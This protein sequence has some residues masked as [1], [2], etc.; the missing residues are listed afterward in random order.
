MEPSEEAK[1]SPTI[2]ST[3]TTTTFEALPDNARA[4]FSITGKAAVTVALLPIIGHGTDIRIGLVSEGK[5]VPAT[6]PIPVISAYSPST[7][8]DAWT[9]VALV[10][11]RETKTARLLVNGL[12]EA[13][14]PDVAAGSFDGVAKA[15]LKDKVRYYAGVV[16][17]IRLWSIGRDDKDIGQTMHTRSS[18]V[19]PYLAGYW[20]L[21][22]GT[23]SLCHDSTGLSRPLRLVTDD[24]SLTVGKSWVLS[25]ANITSRAGIVR[26]VLRLRDG[27][28]VTTA[29]A[30]ALYC[31]QEDPLQNLAEEKEGKGDSVSKANKTRAHVVLAFGVRQA[32]PSSG[33]PNGSED[34][35]LGCLGLLDFDLD[36]QGILASTTGL[37]G[38]ESSMLT[39]ALLVNNSAARAAAD[40]RSKRIAEI[41]K[42][43]A[44]FHEKVKQ[45]QKDRTGGEWTWYGPALGKIAER[46]RA[47]ETDWDREIT[48]LKTIVVGDDKQIEDVILRSAEWRQQ[49]R[50]AAAEI[51]HLDQAFPT[52][53]AELDAKFNAETDWVET[54]P[55]RTWLAAAG[56]SKEYVKSKALLADWYRLVPSMAGECARI[57][58]EWENARHKLAIDTW[59]QKMRWRRQIDLLRTP[60]ADAKIQPLLCSIDAAGLRVSGMMLDAEAC[61]L[62]G[63]PAL[64]ESAKGEILI[65]ARGAGERL[66]SFQYD[67]GSARSIAILRGNATG[68]GPDGSAAVA[69]LPRSN[70]VKQLHVE[71]RRSVSNSSAAVDVLLTAT[72]AGDAPQSV[73]ERWSEVSSDPQQLSATINGMISRTAVQV[74]RIGS[75]DVP[76][77]IVTPTSA[78]TPGITKL[79]FP[80]GTLTSLLPGS[81]LTTGS[82]VFH[83]SRSALAGSKEVEIKILDFPK[84]EIVDPEADDDDPL[85]G[86]PSGSMLTML[87]YDYSRLAWSDRP[88]ANLASGSMIAS[89]VPLDLGVKVSI[90]DLVVTAEHTRT[91][92]LKGV[93]AG[94]S[95]TFDG[96][97][98][99][100]VATSI[101]DPTSEA[102]PATA[103]GTG[104]SVELYFKPALGQHLESA[105]LEDR[106][107]PHRSV[108]MAY[109]DSVKDATVSSTGWARECVLAL[110]R[111]IDT[112]TLDHYHVVLQFRGNGIFCPA[113]HIPSI[114]S[115]SFTVE[116]QVWFTGGN[117]SQGGV[118]LKVEI[119]DFVIELKREACTVTYRSNVDGQPDLSGIV[120]APLGDIG[121][122]LQVETWTHVSVVHDAARR[123]AD[124]YLDGENVASFAVPN[125]PDQ[126]IR[127]QGLAVS[128]IFSAPAQIADVAVWHGICSPQRSTRERLRRFSTEMAEVLLYLE[129]QTDGSVR[130]ISSNGFPVRVDSPSGAQATRRSSQD[131]HWQARD[132]WVLVGQL[133]GKP[134]RLRP[135][136]TSL[137]GQICSDDWTHVAVT[138]DI[139]YAASLDNLY[140][141]QKSVHFRSC[142]FIEISGNAPFTDG[143]IS[144]AICMSDVGRDTMLLTCG[145]AGLVKGATECR[146]NPLELST[147]DGGRLRIAWVD[148]HGTVI[149]RETNCRLRSGVPTRITLTREYYNFSVASG[150]KHIYI[151]SL[152][153]L[154]CPR[155]QDL[156]GSVREQWP[157]KIDPASLA[158]LPDDLAVMESSAFWFLGGAPWI[159][160]SNVQ[161]DRQDTDVEMDG[162]TG[163]I[164]EFRV[165]QG[166]IDPYPPSTPRGVSA[167]LVTWLNFVEGE[168]LRAADHAGKA[169]GVFS[170]K[171]RPTWSISLNPHES[172]ISA[173]LDGISIELSPIG[174]KWAENVVPTTSTLVLGGYRS[175]GTTSGDRLSNFSGS[176][177]EVRLWNTCRTEEMINDSLYYPLPEVDPS[178]LAYYDMSPPSTILQESATGLLEGFNRHEHLIEDKS[179]ASRHLKAINKPKELVPKWYLLYQDFDSPVGDAAPCYMNPFSTREPT[180]PQ[181]KADASSGGIAE[182]G[183]VE[184]DG[185]GAYKRVYSHISKDGEWHLWTG[186]KVGEV[187]SSYVASQQSAAEIKGFIEGPPP[188]PLENYWSK[189]RE[190]TPHSVVR[191]MDMGRT[192]FTYN[193]R[194]EFGKELSE[195]TDQSIGIKWKVTVGVGVET[196]VS[197]G[198]AL[199]NLKTSADFNDSSYRTDSLIRTD[200]RT[201]E[202]KSEQTGQWVG[203]DDDFKYDVNNDGLALVESRTCDV[204]ALRL[205]LKGGRWPLIAYDVRPNLLIPPDVNI[206]TFPLNPRYVKQGCLDGNHGEVADPDYAAD[207]EE[208][209]KLGLG[210]S[211]YD[212]KDAYR[213][214][215]QI[216][217]QKEIREA[218]YASYSEAVESSQVVLGTAKAALHTAQ[219]ILH[220][221]NVMDTLAGKSTMPKTTTRSICNSYVWTASGGFYSE[222]NETIDHI[223][224]EYGSSA[225]GKMTIGGGLIGDGFIGALD[226]ASQWHLG[227]S[228]HFNINSHKDKATESHYQ[229]HVE[230]GTGMDLRIVKNQKDWSKRAGAVDA[231]RWMTF[232]EEPS[233]DHWEVLFNKVIDPM[234]LAGQGRD[235]DTPEASLLRST[236]NSGAKSKCWRISHRVTFV[237]RVLSK[238][239]PRANDDDGDAARL[240]S[241]LHRMNLDSNW[242][243][244]QALGPQVASCGSKGAIATRLRMVLPHTYPLLLQSEVVIQ[245]VVELLAEYMGLV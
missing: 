71:I 95:I 134:F 176:L 126:P 83:V 96:G 195:S 45:I 154:E 27:L 125:L 22:E 144:M 138:S 101:V 213:L 233:E 178:L 3:S 212:P 34:A 203:T 189:A 99:V 77:A 207:G 122:R 243:L 25:T 168:G 105:A 31:E 14:M 216:R 91:P 164:S 146:P 20:G 175:D 141:S 171:R 94:G 133:C 73:R 173:Y 227:A 67:A 39:N 166:T 62:T 75:D 148:R 200:V 115:E 15:T 18:G 52:R 33:S 191:F 6:F 58:R 88:N 182:Y 41:D 220:G 28:E 174:S 49:S 131:V 151:V 129:G 239:K 86:P 60:P 143:T 100:S 64:Y 103:L 137:A 90:Q 194:S 59:K 63:A 40:V 169:Q 124:V 117:A 16:D 188:F 46:R 2:P 187:V 102:R 113:F 150:A 229:V 48:R 80:Q 226:I 165:Y 159:V 149:H 72:L 156:A 231:Y 74:G 211:Y 232:F 85:P 5:V 21:D 167:G 236:K 29:P 186:H 1:P 142:S 42:D 147:F 38:L 202:M 205:K 208:R 44:D 12:V 19:E 242:Q 218:E 219:D 198:K 84:L 123:S 172:C 230:S 139:S 241:Q 210:V 30:A 47:V 109:S 4:V 234:W 114:R 136:A 190:H 157:E 235:G 104:L 81:V 118:G 135:S 57:R 140:T 36:A 170:G 24:T 238:I 11:K 97:N 17:E 121:H 98:S 70:A 106:A 93:V 112:V 56:D 76:T 116:F 244:I 92:G 181:I 127:K 209:R 89:F 245:D 223:Q 163:Q 196:E 228:L 61:V 54:G 55:R 110:E 184:A 65:L 132:E 120:P 224:N 183:E 69:V 225:I 119:D 111:D 160:N 237:S 177:A 206:V 26:R 162:L 37:I 82:W 193:T 240:S 35:S 158:A 214:R 108:L 185:T 107:N 192:V 179:L 53:L 152:A 68:E 50:V 215:D 51:T 161:A 204:Y 222:S 153:L 13:T 128:N 23:G 197:S 217:K 9:H 221:R 87:A 10:Y 201:V 145:D 180:A 130:D 79:Q 32:N 7:P 8:S 155:G 43:E 199:A 66:Q 78:K